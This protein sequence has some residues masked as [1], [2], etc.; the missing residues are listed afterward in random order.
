[1]DDDNSGGAAGISVVIY[2]DNG[3]SSDLL[4]L[5]RNVVKNGQRVSKGQVVG[6]S[7]NTG[8]STG[9]HLHWTVRNKQTTGY[10]NYGNLNGEKYVSHEAWEDVKAVQTRAN[11]WLV[12][13][14]LSKITVDGIFGNQTTNAIKSLQSRWGIAVDGVVG[15]VTWKYLSKTPEPV[16]VP[17]PRF[18]VTFDA[19]GGAPTPATQSI[20]EGDTVAV[21]WAPTRVAFRFGGWY[22]GDQPFD[23]TSAITEDVTVTAKWI[24]LS[25]PIHPGSDGST[26]TK[27]SK[28][29]V[30]NPVAGGIAGLVVLAVTALGAWIASMVS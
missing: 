4:H 7:G 18:V 9:P 23:F 15:P 2:H 1:V 29:V 8:A 16:E 11:V 21:P 26:Q 19:N 13:Y 12:H 22:R 6:Y 5:S 24:E 30:S 20:E 27:P 3:W 14:G 25:P 10:Y 28:P 17:K